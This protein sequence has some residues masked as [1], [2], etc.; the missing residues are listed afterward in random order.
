MKSS[1]FWGM[2]LAFVRALQKAVK[3][4]CDALQIQCI[5]PWRKITPKGREVSP[6]VERGAA[7]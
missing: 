1:V 5:I 2:A 4:L 3:I 7:G 6:C